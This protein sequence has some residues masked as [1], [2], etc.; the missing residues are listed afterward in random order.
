MF[1]V[2]GV[3]LEQTVFTRK[4]LLGKHWQCSSD[5]FR[6]V[7]FS[8]GQQRPRTWKKKIARARERLHITAR[9]PEMDAYGEF[10]L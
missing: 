6:R 7:I 4:N 9:S 8:A 5:N 2:I 10:S 3:Q 1:I